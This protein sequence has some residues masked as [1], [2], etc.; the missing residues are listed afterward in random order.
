MEDLIEEKLKKEA[1]KMNKQFG[2]TDTHAPSYINYKNTWE[3]TFLLWGPTHPKLYVWVCS[4]LHFWTFPLIRSN[5]QSCSSR[6]RLCDFVFFETRKARPWVYRK[7]D[8]GLWVHGGVAPNWGTGEIGTLEELASI[9][10]IQLRNNPTQDKSPK[11]WGQGQ[12]I[13]AAKIT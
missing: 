4:S 12:R 11:S 8:H 5:S 2:W 9:W 1:E 13:A 3:K 7:R 10:W 6:G